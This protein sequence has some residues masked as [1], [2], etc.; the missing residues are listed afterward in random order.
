MRPVYWF[1]IVI[2]II[3]IVYVWMLLDTNPLKDYVL[4]VMDGNIDD[5]GIVGKRY[6]GLRYPNDVSW[7][8]AIF[9]IFV[10]H[11]FSNGVM[12]VKYSRR[13]YKQNGDYYGVD[14]NILSKWTI[15]KEN[16][17]WKVIDIDEHP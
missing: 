2:A 12:W 13:G 1:I 7:D 9:R 5:Q 3:S 4:L 6:S 15:H 14:S 16:G 8:N 17:R 10:A 11:N